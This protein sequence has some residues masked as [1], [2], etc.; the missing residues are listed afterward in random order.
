MEFQDKGWVF[1]QTAKMTIVYP[2]EGTVEESFSV[3]GKV[4]SLEELFNNLEVSSMEELQEK[5][6]PFGF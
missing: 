3:E 2:P 4:S 5:V 1:H 6:N